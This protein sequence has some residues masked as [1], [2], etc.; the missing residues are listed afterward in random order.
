[1]EPFL[2]KRRGIAKMHHP[3]THEFLLPLYSECKSTHEHRILTRVFAAD[4]P[5]R[6]KHCFQYARPQFPPSPQFPLKPCLREQHERKTRITRSNPKI[7]NLPQSQRE[8]E[9]LPTYKTIHAVRLDPTIHK[10][11]SKKIVIPDPYQTVGHSKSQMIVPNIVGVNLEKMKRG[12][13]TVNP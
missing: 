7:L 1:M 2:I 11:S 12:R 9:I 8:I 13:S 3:H 6:P 10:Y 5:D 4:N